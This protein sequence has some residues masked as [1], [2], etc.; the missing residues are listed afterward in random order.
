MMLVIAKIFL[1]YV[2]LIG[3]ALADGPPQFFKDS[4]PEHAMAKILESYGALQGEGSSLDPKTRE[5]IALG[6]AAQIPCPYCV[7][8]H[9]NNARKLGATEAEIKEAAATAG[10]VRLFSTLFQAAEI[11]LDA[12]KSEH[13]EIRAASQ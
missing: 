10:Y 5:L 4:L 9:K 2:F 7:Y 11:D 13:D 8:A 6:V 12:F 3:A 1:I